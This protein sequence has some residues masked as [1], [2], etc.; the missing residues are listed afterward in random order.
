MCR[1]RSGYVVASTRAERVVLTT[2][3]GRAASPKLRKGDF[4]VA[5]IGLAAELELLT[6]LFGQIELAGDHLGGGDPLARVAQHRMRKRVVDLAALKETWPA[7]KP[8]I[9]T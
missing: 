5:D 3:F 6:D 7:I 1:I 2:F 8:I 9:Y 4:V